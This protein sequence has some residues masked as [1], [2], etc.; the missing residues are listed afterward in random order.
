MMHAD[1]DRAFY[2]YRHVALANEQGAVDTLLITDGLFRAANPA[3]R[4]RYVTLVES[5]RE[6]GG[7]VALFSSAHVSGEQLAQVTGVAAILRF[8]LPDLAEDEGEGDP[9]L[10]GEAAAGAGHADEDEGEVAQLADALAMIPPSGRQS[11]DTPG[12][13]GP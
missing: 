9:V 4:R 13:G 2:G 8:P 1:P 5:V 7:K 12:E 6:R 10:D 3:L 11:P